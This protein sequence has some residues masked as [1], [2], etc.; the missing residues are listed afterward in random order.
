MSQRRGSGPLLHRAFP[1]SALSLTQRMQRVQW[2]EAVVGQAGLPRLRRNRAALTRLHAHRGEPDRPKCPASR[3][4]GRRRPSGFATFANATSS[5]RSATG[6]PRRRKSGMEVHSGR[7]ADRRTLEPVRGQ[8]GTSL[9]PPGL[10][11]LRSSWKRRPRRRRRPLRA[12]APLE[13]RE[14]GHVPRRSPR[15]T[16][17]DEGHACCSTRVASAA[18]RLATQRG[19]RPTRRPAAHERDRPGSNATS[20]SRA[21]YFCPSRSLAATQATLVEELRAEQ[22]PLDA[23]VA[24]APVRG[25][26]RALTGCPGARNAIPWRMARG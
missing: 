17:T 7:R 18:A 4:G 13:P 1:S 5:D 24:A 2:H 22:R 10:D 26:E 25:R 8:R 6:T 23:L 16:G 11:L 14:S 20:S 21:T 19:S 3:S 9:H 12:D 15:P